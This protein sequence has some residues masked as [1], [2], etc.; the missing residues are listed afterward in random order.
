MLASWPAS[1]MDTSRKHEI[2]G[3]EMTYDVLLIAT[4]VARVSAFLH[5]FQ[6]PDSQR[7]M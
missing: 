2:P 6:T 3:L 1:F 7:I 4:A 5:W